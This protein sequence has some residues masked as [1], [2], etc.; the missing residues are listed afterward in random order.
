MGRW[1]LCGVER[2]AVDKQG[3]LRLAQ[4]GQCLHLGSWSWWAHSVDAHGLGQ[5]QQ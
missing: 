3:L 1:E 5:S 4:K 2:G